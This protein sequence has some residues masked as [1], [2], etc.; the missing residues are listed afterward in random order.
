MNWIEK[1]FF[2]RQKRSNE[3]IVVSSKPVLLSV[4]SIFSIVW[5]DGWR[6]PAAS[7]MLASG[8]ARQAH[9]SRLRSSSAWLI[10]VC[11][12][13]SKSV[14]CF[15]LLLCVHALRRVHMMG[16]RRRSHFTVSY[17]SQR[18]F[19]RFISALRDQWRLRP[20]SV[21]EHFTLVISAIH[22]MCRHGRHRHTA[23]RFFSWFDCWLCRAGCTIRQQYVHG[24]DASRDAKGARWRSYTHRT[25]NRIVCDA[26]SD[27]LVVIRVHK[28]RSGLA[29]CGV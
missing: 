18:T 16:I 7:S 19:S 15:F 9:V 10:L 2:W 14:V 13:I 5:M 20:R 12:F 25:R 24:C 27:W 21:A 28:C 23:T 1:F 3:R 4:W 11:V 8:Q 17:V 22:I 6:A 26:I 29:W